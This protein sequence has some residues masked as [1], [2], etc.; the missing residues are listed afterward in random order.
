MVLMRSPPSLLKSISAAKMGARPGAPAE[1]GH[2]KTADM[3]RKVVT[4]W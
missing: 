3:R 4:T 2:A 1:F